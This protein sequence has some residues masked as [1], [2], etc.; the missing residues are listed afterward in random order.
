MLELSYETNYFIHFFALESKQDDT[1]GGLSR[2][3]SYFLNSA[4][5]ESGKY[6]LF[7]AQF[8]SPGLAYCFLSSQ[9]VS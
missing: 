1:V 8:C 6:I 3:K 7:P 2:K 5:P 9:L 4:F